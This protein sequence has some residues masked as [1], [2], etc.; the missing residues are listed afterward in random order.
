M[1]YEMVRFNEKNLDEALE[2][3]S[4]AFKH[5]DGIKKSFAEMYPRIFGPEA[6]RIGD[7]FCAMRDG[8]V[9]GCISNDMMEYHVGGE[10][11]K[12]SSS[13][14]VAVKE[15]ERGRGLMKVMFDCVHQDLIDGEFDVSYLHGARTRYNYFGYELCGVEYIFKFEMADL[16]KHYKNRHLF[17]F[18]DLRERQDLLEEAIKINEMQKVYI[19]RRAESLINVFLARWREPVAVFRDGKL[20]GTFAFGENGIKYITLK[21]YSDFAEMVFEFLSAKGLEET[22]YWAPDYNK[23]LIGNCM[24]NCSSFVIGNPANFKIM[25]FEKV[26]KAFLQLKAD[27]E[28]LCDG[29]LTLDSDLFGKFRIA[30]EG[31]MVTVGK[32]EG[33]ATYKLKGFEVYDFLFNHTPI[34]YGTYDPTVES[35]LPIPINAPYLA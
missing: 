17:E 2:V 20:F 22:E 31:G 28:S 16:S 8:E 9:V 21:D 10:V 18:V 19:K 15:S 24:K 25:N 7:N 14:N 11:L 5:Q 34:S 30:I 13:G 35:W 12:I 33:E 26:V 29:E 27:N 32:Y 1:T 23:Q 3:L 6:E 4:E